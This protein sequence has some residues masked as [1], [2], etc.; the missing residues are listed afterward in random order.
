MAD[1]GGAVIDDAIILIENNRIL[2]VGR[3]HAHG[4]EGNDKLIPQQNWDAIAHLVFGVTTINNPNSPP[5]LSDPATELH[6]SGGCLR[7]VEP[8]KLA[9]LVI[10]DADPTVDIRNSDKVHRVM[11][12]GRLYDPRTMNED[13]TGAWRRAPYDWE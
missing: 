11:L 9:D 12:Y 7:H 2:Q 10:L 3:C 4:A 5:A 6:A 13:V 8:G 1:A